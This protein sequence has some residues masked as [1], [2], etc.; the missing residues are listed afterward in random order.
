MADLGDCSQLYVDAKHDYRARWMAAATLTRGVAHFLMA[1]ETGYF[2]GIEMKIIKRIVTFYSAVLCAF[3]AN[4]ALLSRGGNLYYDDVLNVTWIG[5]VDLLGTQASK[6][7]NFVPEL[8]SRVSSLA[9]PGGGYLSYDQVGNSGQ[10]VLSEADFIV[11]SGDTSVA[12]WYGAQA[13]A[14]QLVYAGV[15]GWRVAGRTYFDGGVFTNEVRHLFVQDFGL[16]HFGDAGNANEISK[17]FKI[18]PY[19]DS[20]HPFWL[21]DY[22]GS[23]DGLMY[24]SLA[25]FLGSSTLLN[26]ANFLLVRDGDV[27]AVPEPNSAVLAVVALMFCGWSVRRSSINQI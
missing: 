4:A 8:I 21:S 14:D 1:R 15:S 2:S 9:V 5:D 11:R 3:G 23:S 6:D 27:A 7:S 17:F 19:S 10:Y 26:R 16:T 24:L 22:H 13:Y 20:A 12:T 18:I 25:D